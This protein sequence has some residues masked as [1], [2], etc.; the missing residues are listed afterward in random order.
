MNFGK[1]F[2]SMHRNKVIFYHKNDANSI[3][4]FYQKDYYF[5]GL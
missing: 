3:N 2:T 4:T 1:K 5:I